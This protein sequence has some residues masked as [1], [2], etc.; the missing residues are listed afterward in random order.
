MNQRRFACYVGI[1]FAGLA[2]AGCGSASVATPT[3]TTTAATAPNWPPAGMNAGAD[4]VAWE[5]TAHDEFKC[6]SYQ[7]GCYGITVVSRDGCP[8]GVYI[9]LAIMSDGVAVGKANE[10]TAGLAPGGKAQAVLS[11]PGGAP[12]TATGKLT[13]LNCLS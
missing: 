8:S 10:I 5:W 7:D 13:K 1:A 2:M 11:P 12:S 3:S 4:G 6:K 9:E